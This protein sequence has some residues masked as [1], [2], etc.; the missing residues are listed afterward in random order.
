[1]LSK[2][3]TFSEVLRQLERSGDAFDAQRATGAIFTTD[4]FEIDG[5]VRY[6]AV[7]RSFDEACAIEA[8]LLGTLDS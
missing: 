4:T 1:M 8:R 2:Q 7:A 5:K 6:L 3:R